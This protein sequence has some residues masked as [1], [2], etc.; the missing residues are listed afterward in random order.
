MGYKVSFRKKL[1]HYETEVRINLLPDER[2]KIARSVINAVR[3]DFGKDST[4]EKDTMEKTTKIKCS[5]CKYIYTSPIMPNLGCPKCGSREREFPTDEELRFIGM[6]KTYQD[7]EVAPVI[8][9]R[10]KMETDQWIVDKSC[11]HVL[12]D[13][14]GNYPVQEISISRI[15]ALATSEEIKKDA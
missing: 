2:E 5:K 13:E 1:G 6:Q 15:R 12:K 7:K 3:R 10:Y 8:K 4:E 9:I 14:G 11:A